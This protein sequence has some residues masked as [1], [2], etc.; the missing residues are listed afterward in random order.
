RP[1]SSM[2][3]QIRGTGSIGSG[4]NSGPLVIIDGVPGDADLLNPNDIENISVLKDAAASAIYGSRAPYGVVL[5]TTKKGKSGAMRVSFSTT[6]SIRNP[7]NMLDKMGSLDFMDY[8][9]EGMVNTGNT[10]YFDE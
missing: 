9:N 3:W 7:T 6:T 5:I 8:M 1:G 2:N 4:V 10:P